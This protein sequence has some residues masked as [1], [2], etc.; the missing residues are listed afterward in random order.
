MVS[1]LHSVLLT[2][3]YKVINY[4]ILKIFSLLYLKASEATYGFCILHFLAFQIQKKKKICKYP[5][6]AGCGS[7][8][9]GEKCWVFFI[10]QVSSRYHVCFHLISNKALFLLNMSSEMSQRTWYEMEYLL[11]FYNKYLRYV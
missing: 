7:V 3:P 2:G 8:C 10:F 1:T 11:I 4:S 9:F 5:A 6:Q